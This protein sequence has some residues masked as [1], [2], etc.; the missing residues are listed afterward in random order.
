[1]QLTQILPHQTPDEGMKGV[2]S[3]AVNFFFVFIN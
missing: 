3:T 1:M 2:D